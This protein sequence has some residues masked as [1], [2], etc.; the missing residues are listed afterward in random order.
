MLD[1]G[2]GIVANIPAQWAICWST[3]IPLTKLSA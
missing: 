3:L 1:F 2:F